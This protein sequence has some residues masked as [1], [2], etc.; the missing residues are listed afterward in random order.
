MLTR[1]TVMEGLACLSAAV[2]LNAVA[3]T[4]HLTHHLPPSSTLHA[5]AL[6]RNAAPPKPL[7][8]LDPGHGGRTLEQLVFPVRMR[9][10]LRKRPRLNFKDS[11][12][13]RGN[14]VSR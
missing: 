6:H 13:H 12:W 2:P 4:K 10:I 11:F 5:P 7:V 9:N 1:R 8:M 3:R 14:T